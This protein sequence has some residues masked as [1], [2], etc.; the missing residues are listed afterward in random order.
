[1][2]FAEGHGI[3]KG[4]QEPA[5]ESSLEEQKQCSRATPGESGTA[6]LGQLCG[7]PAAQPGGP[8]FLD[9]GLRIMHHHLEVS[10]LRSQVFQG[11]AS[12][13]C[14]SGRPLVSHVQRATAQLIQL[15]CGKQIV[16]LGQSIVRWI[17]FGLPCLPNRP[18]WSSYNYSHQPLLQGGQAIV[19][20]TSTSVPAQSTLMYFVCLCELNA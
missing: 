11:L 12:L 20:P 18:R 5:E 9:A 6:G 15:D 8:G 16:L 19:G 4:S 10:D 1:M 2:S 14:S 3:Q 17:V 13:C 7:G